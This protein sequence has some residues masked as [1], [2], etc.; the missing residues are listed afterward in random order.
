[1]K[2]FMILLLAVVSQAASANY[3]FHFE[4]SCHTPASVVVRFQDTGGVWR[5]TGWYEFAPGEEAFLASDD[6]R[7][8]ES[9]NATFYYY[10]KMIG[11]A[12]SWEGSDQD[13]RDR[14]YQVDGEP[15]RFRH[16]RDRWWDN[17][18]T[19][20]CSNVAPPPQL[21]AYLFALVQVAEKRYEAGRIATADALV[22]QLA[23]TAYAEADE[24]FRSGLV[25]GGS[26]P[27]VLC[28]GGLDELECQLVRDVVTNERIKEAVATWSGLGAGFACGAG[29][30]ATGVGLIVSIPAAVVCNIVFNSATRTVFN[31]GISETQRSIIGHITGR[32]TSCLEIGFGLE[33]VL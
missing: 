7:R 30:A 10:A 8:L 19:L 11:S 6:R 20:G 26:G 5:T 2:T 21:S 9:R 22:N 24:V 1:M 27:T 23:A 28:P 15:L 25:G 14:T 4:N 13:P 3:Y 18:V 16:V 33:W 29:V 17:N 12:H 31:C 32:D